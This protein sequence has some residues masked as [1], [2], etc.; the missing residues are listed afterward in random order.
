MGF[1]ISVFVMIVI[2]GHCV[3]VSGQ[4]VVMN[5]IVMCDNH[6]LISGDHIVMGTSSSDPTSL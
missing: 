5:I 1:L 3:M 2:R 6:I 4:R